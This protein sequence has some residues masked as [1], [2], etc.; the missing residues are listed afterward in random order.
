[1]T[2]LVSAAETAV[3]P[4]LIWIKLGVAVLAIV[5]LLGTGFYA[6]TRWDQNT[7]TQMKLTDQK[8]ANKAQA[9][10]AT[11][12]KKQDTVS[13]TA[14]S[15]E[16]NAQAKIVTRTITLT[17]EI[18]HDVPTTVACIP[19]GLVRL[20]N[21]AAAGADSADTSYAPGQP[22]DA[23][24]PVSWRDF[25]SDLADDYGTGHANAE[26]LT[27]LQAWVTAESKAVAP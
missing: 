17:K 16:A 27:A 25:A 18:D 1:M 11:I 3:N 22:D 26:Q 6:G 7:I 20:L 2:D 14:A 8:A 5:G 15:T 10:A 4:Y 24:A 12:T 21:G 13:V 19:V 23:C 9:L